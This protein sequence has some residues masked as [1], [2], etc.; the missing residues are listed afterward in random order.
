MNLKNFKFALPKT[1][2]EASRMGAENQVVMRVYHISP[3]AKFSS[4]QLQNQPMP[5][6]D[7]NVAIT[8][9]APPT[10]NTK[11]LQGFYDSM[12]AMV[13]SGMMP[14]EWNMG[15]LN[16]LWKG[17]TASPNAERPGESDMACDI[18]IIQC[19]DEETALQTLKNKALM[20]TQGFDVP[21]PGFTGAPGMPKNMSMSDLLQSDMLKSMMTKEQAAQL[22]KM[23]GALKEAKRQMPQVKKEFEKAG[24]KYHEGKLFGCKVM[25]YESPNQTP[26]PAP[27]Q[28][29][30]S[31][32]NFAGGGGGYGDLGLDPLPKA[33]KPYSP[34]NTFYLGILHKNFIINGSLMTMY[35]SLPSSNTPCYSLSQTKRVTRTSREGGTLFTDIFIVPLV[36]N[37]AKEGY[38]YKEEVEKIFRGIIAKLG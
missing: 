30:S 8:K 29:S 31:K 10:P 12:K 36:S 17:M 26:P 5:S 3:I 18:D 27:K 4:G 11:P 15:K 6:G 21:I 33:E 35:D 9:V 14:P 23:K 7:P 24:I 16:D 22:E 13:Q 19:Q 25:Y 38:M 28:P 32:K 1:W 20:P 34:T 37:Y 2:R